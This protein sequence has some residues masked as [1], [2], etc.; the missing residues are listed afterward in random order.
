MRAVSHGLPLRVG[1]RA[2]PAEVASITS[3]VEGAQPVVFFHGFPPHGF[4]WRHVLHELG[5]EIHGL[6][7]DLLG[8]GDT[9]VSPYEDVTAP[10]QAELLFEVVPEERPVELA[11]LLRALL[12]R[13][14]AT[15]Q[16]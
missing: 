10:T 7:P 13:P 5:D 6:A 15:A 8:V 9:A 4:L 3:G 1:V 16:G 12:D 14:A 11:G 2:G